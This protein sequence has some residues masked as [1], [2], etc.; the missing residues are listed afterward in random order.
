[1]MPERLW[2]MSA[3]QEYKNGIVLLFLDGRKM[4]TITFIWKNPQFYFFKING[5]ICIAHLTLPDYFS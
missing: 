1:M 5:K 3:L 4:V 2:R